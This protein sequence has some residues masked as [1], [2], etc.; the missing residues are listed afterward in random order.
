MGAPQ[1]RRQSRRPQH[2][3]RLYGDGGLQAE[4]DPRALLG[5]IDS[6]RGEDA[7][8]FPAY[9]HTAGSGRT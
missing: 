4:D 2:A 8:V 5:G 9:R 6:W 3:R 7:P 1:E